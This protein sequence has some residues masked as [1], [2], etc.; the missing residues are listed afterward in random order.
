M[1]SKIGFCSS[2]CLLL[3]ES[4]HSIT[5]K[6]LLTK[7]SYYEGH[8][9]HTLYTEIPIYLVTQEP[10]HGWRV[11]RIKGKVDSIGYKG[12]IQVQRA[13]LAFVCATDMTPS[14]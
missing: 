2:D 3:L 8:S 9:T 1:L 7:N 14:T 13:R 5:M 6:K 10:S 4:N 11:E 12:Y